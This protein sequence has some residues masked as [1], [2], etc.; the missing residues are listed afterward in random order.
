M[1]A[2][3]AM[4]G[5]SSSGIVEAASFGL[6]VVDIGNR[7]KGRIRGRNVLNADPTA[8]SIVRAIKKATDPTF[9]SDIDGMD[10]PYGDGNAAAR[11]VDVLESRTLDAAL[12]Q[13]EFHDLA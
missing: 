3:S 9:R 6:P 2:A 1:G 4:V 5:N 12:L 8:D 10:N 13:K 7:Q 11:I